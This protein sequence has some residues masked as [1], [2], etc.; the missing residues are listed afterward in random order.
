MI[1]D[2]GEVPRRRVQVDVSRLNIYMDLNI[3]MRIQQILRNE[4]G[5]MYQANPSSEYV[6]ITFVLSSLKRV[7]AML[8]TE[9]PAKHKDSLTK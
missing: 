2:L 4:S 8:T 1:L 9:K 7:R 3:R 5:F 6:A